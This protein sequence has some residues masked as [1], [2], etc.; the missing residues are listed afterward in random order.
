LSECT[1][2]LTINKPIRHSNWQGI[3]GHRSRSQ[4]SIKP[5]KSSAR[6][7]GMGNSSGDEINSP[8]IRVYDEAGNMIDTHEY[9]GDFTEP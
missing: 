7:C 3:L 9:K 5:E 6:V 4:R 2:K 8:V 1:K